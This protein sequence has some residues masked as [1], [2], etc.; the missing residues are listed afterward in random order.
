MGKNRWKLARMT[1][2]RDPSSAKP[3]LSMR[4]YSAFLEIPGVNLGLFSVVR[5]GCKDGPR[6]K[7]SASL[8]KTPRGRAFT[9]GAGGN[10]DSGSMTWMANSWESSD[11]NLQEK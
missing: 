1:Q 3:A 11:R 4:S 6:G 9:C 7:H 2:V 5:V 10:S 8:G